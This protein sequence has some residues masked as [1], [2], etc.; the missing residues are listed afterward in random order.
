MVVNY[1]RQ[2]NYLQKFFNNM[3][4]CKN[5]K[6]YQPISLTRE[7]APNFPNGALGPSPPLGCWRHGLV[8]EVPLDVVAIAQ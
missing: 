5:H 2:Q 8:K 1:D 7:R 4:G 6:T 3:N